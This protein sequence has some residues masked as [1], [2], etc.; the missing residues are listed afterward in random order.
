MKVHREM[1]QGSLDWLELRAGI[2]TASEADQLVTPKF[3][4]RTGEMVRT[5]LATKLAEKWLGPLPAFGSWATEQGQLLEETAIP[6][7]EL[8]Y[9]EQVEKVGFITADDGRSGCSPDGLLPNCGIEVKS[10]QPV[11]HIKCLMDGGLPDDYAPQVHFSMMVTGFEQWKFFAYSRR[12]PH[13]L[14]TVQRDE[15]IQSVLADAL[16]VF[17][18]TFDAEWQRLCERNGGPPPKRKVFVPSPESEDN[19]YVDI[20]P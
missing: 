13:L 18:K 9:G 3:K 12:L 15:A 19:P 8:E 7:Y 4:I 17:L 6:A 20:N 16:D 1:Q 5:L 14:V 10:L 11:H 2:V